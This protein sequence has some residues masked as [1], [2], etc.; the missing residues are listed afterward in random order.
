MVHQTKIQRREKTANYSA[1]TKTKKP[2]AK[3][4]KLKK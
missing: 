2:A 4:K 3:K 1:K